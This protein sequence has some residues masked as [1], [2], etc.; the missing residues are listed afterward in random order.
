MK[1]TLGYCFY[2]VAEIV[3][4]REDRNGPRPQ[5]MFVLAFW[6]ALMLVAFL[7]TFC[8]YV[9]DVVGVYESWWPPAEGFRNPANPRTHIWLALFMLGMFLAYCGYRYLVDNR[10][11]IPTRRRSVK[12]FIAFMLLCQWPA[13]VLLASFW[14]GGVLFQ[15]VVHGAT[16]ALVHHRVKRTLTQRAG[17][18]SE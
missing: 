4:G 16:L 6:F 13:A 2:F 14:L 5:A 15:S 8:T 3:G 10:I 9:F 11:G 7:L 12:D 18:A 1:R 17:R